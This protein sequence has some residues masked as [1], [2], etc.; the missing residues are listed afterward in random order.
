M[1]RLPDKGEK[2]KNFRAQIEAEL[3]NHRR[4]ENLC[5]D[6]VSLD[7]SKSQLDTL[8]WTGKQRVPDANG[9]RGGQLDI[10]NDRDVLKM[11][12]THSGIC[13]DKIFIK[14]TEPVPLSV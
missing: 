1:D 14:Y 12:V 6:M 10:D 4:Y 3:N 9:E 2:V 7:V 8:E 11:F 5:E 13:Q